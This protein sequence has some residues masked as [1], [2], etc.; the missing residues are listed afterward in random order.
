MSGYA[1]SLR[2]GSDNGYDM[3]SVLNSR[4]FSL[5]LSKYAGGRG[6]GTVLGRYIN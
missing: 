6:F 5:K 1:S 3:N 2:L 4:N